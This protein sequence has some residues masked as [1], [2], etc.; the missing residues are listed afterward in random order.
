LLLGQGAYLIALRYADEDLRDRAFHLLSEPGSNATP[1]ALSDRQTYKALERLDP[2]I[3]VPDYDA[4]K[5]AHSRFLMYDPD[6]W[7]LERLIDEGAEIKIQ[8]TLQHGP[9][10]EVVLKS[11]VGRM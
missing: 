11:N 8:A 7:V 10:Y 3:R 9:L 1:F 4:F 2:R 5:R 6:Q